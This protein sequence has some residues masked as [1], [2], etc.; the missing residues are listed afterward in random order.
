MEKKGFKVKNKE[1]D[2]PQVTSIEVSF[3]I[4]VSFAFLPITLLGNMAA[5][6]MEENQAELLA[7]LNEQAAFYTYFKDMDGIQSFQVDELTDAPTQSPTSYEHYLASQAALNATFVE[8]EEGSGGLGFMVL[9]GLAIGALWCCLTA[10][11]ISFLYVS[12]VG[13]MLFLS[14]SSILRYLC[15][16]FISTTFIQ[17]L[18]LKHVQK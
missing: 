3:I 7:L 11:T 14:C 12:F 5:V 9:V 18:G 16:I 13:F 6:A 1:P 2:Y 15:F 10:I 4:R 17:I 8:E